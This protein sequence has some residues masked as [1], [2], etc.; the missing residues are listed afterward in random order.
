MLRASKLPETEGNDLISGFYCMNQGW[1][2]PLPH[3]PTE[4]IETTFEDLV[5]SFS[6]WNFS[7][8]W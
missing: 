2:A 8:F 4:D 6:Q 5:E 7:S 3:I 1:F